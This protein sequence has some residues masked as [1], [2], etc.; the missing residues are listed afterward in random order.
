[1]LVAGVL[2]V[3]FLAIYSYYHASAG[4]AKFG[5]VGPIRTVYFSLLAIH[6]VMAAVAA[7]L[8]PIVVFFALKQRFDIHR[9][10]ACW[11][12][13]IWLFVSAS[14]LVVYAMAVH[15][16]PYQAARSS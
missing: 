11:A 12:L 3:A 1:M 2:G 5:G 4:L 16:Y 7:I 6:V 9:R 8:V 15:L 14:G 10:L 13:P